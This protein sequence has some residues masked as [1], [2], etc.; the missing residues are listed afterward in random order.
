MLIWPD[1][2]RGKNQA[3][4]LAPSGEGHVEMNTSGGYNTKSAVYLKR[5]GVDLNRPLSDLDQGSV[6]SGCSVR[7]TE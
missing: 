1:F 4:P 3:N 7:D 6:A 5:W 2:L